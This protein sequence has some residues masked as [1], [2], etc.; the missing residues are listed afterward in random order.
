MI[1]SYDPL[2]NQYEFEKKIKIFKNNGF[3]KLECIRS[4]YKITNYGKQFI[5]AI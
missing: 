3:E 5:N 1:I 2:L 4:F